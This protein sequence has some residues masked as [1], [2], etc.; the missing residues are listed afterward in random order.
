[1]LLDQSQ[2]SLAA[3]LAKALYSDSVEDL[4]SVFCFSEDQDMRLDPL[5]IEKTSCGCV[6]INS[7][8]R[9]QNTWILKLS[10]RGRAADGAVHMRFRDTEIDGDR[11]VLLMEVIKIKVG[12]SESGFKGGPHIGGR[13]E[14]FLILGEN[15]LKEGGDLRRSKVVVYRWKILGWVEVGFGFGF[16][17]LPWWKMVLVATSMKPRAGRKGRS[18]LLN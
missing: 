17:R 2:V 11:T 14:V 9:H 16:G 15:I 3:A 6:I 1:M 4:A 5:K 12:R 13:P 10:I 18:S 8:L 7:G